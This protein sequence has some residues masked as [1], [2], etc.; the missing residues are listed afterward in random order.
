MPRPKNSSREHEHD[1]DPVTYRCRICGQDEIVLVLRNAGYDSA[2][3]FPNE[4]LT[5][6]VERRRRT[7]ETKN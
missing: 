4:T 1:I 2:E 5:E 6:F 7:G 3:F